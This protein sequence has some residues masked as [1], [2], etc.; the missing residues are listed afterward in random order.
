M[1]PLRRIF[2]LLAFGPLLVHS[3]DMESEML[4]RGDQVHLGPGIGQE[5]GGIGVQLNVRI[6]PSVVFFTGL[7]YAIGGPGVNAG[8]QWRILPERRF[9]PTLS[10]MYGYV[11][12]IRLVN[13][14]TDT[15]QFQKVYY[16][17]SFGAGVDLN[18]RR[19]TN[20]LRLAI[21]YPVRPQRYEDDV[22]KLKADPAVRSF[23]E[24]PP[25]TVSVG[26]FFTI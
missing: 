1:P 7:G 16:G 13:K 14:S 6:V 25:I 15:V 18:G 4:D 21:I 19:N 5:F 23:S 2:V 9:C 17:P 8:G 26:Y 11:A 22:E 3:Q 12:A 20:F 24:L 10:A